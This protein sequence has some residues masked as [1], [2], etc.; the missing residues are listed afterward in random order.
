M[1]ATRSSIMLPL[2]L[3]RYSGYALAV[4]G[5]VLATAIRLALDPVLGRSLPFAFFV[6]TVVLIAWMCGVGPS[7]LAF[8]L[9]LFPG[10]GFFILPYSPGSVPGPADLTGVILYI[11]ISLIVIAIRG[12]ERRMVHRIE[13]EASRRSQAE[14]VVR[15][16]KDRYELAIKASGHILYDYNCAS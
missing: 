16:W 8:V 10:I 5:V 11:F 6:L 12:A 3:S 1:R 7:L 13:V 4:A 9:G 15:E 14:Q 2:R